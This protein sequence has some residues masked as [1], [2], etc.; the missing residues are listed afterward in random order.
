MAQKDMLLREK[1]EHSGIFSFSGAYKFA[2]NW[3]SNEED[4]GVVEEKY[5]EKVSG[6]SKDITVEWVAAKRMGDY[7]KVEIKIEISAEGL[8]EVEVESDGQKKKM[9]KG[10]IKFD[11]KGALIKDPSSKW[12]GKPFDLVL[13]GIYNKFVVPQ[14]IESMEGKVVG[15]VQSLK[16]ELKA[17]LELEAKR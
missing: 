17:Y 5:S 6:N 15:D 3:L 1:L 9:Q 12:E 2:H 16:D 14:T 11:F 7:F 10:K 4:Y 13:R 8:V